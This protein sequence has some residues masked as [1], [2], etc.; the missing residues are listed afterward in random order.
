MKAS[1]YR[2]LAFA[3]IDASD[4][5]ARNK[6]RTGEIENIIYRILNFADR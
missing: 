4:K 2:Q 3:I 6:G 1:P 5:A